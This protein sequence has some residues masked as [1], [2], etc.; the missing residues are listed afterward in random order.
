M[1]EMGTICTSPLPR[2]KADDVGL[3]MMMMVF[4]RER[5][6]HADRETGNNGYG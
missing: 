3:S 5:L 4:A 2:A 6:R 1:T